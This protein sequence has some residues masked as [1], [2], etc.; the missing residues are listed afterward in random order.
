MYTY[1][2]VCIKRIAP[3]ALIFFYFVLCSRDVFA[4]QANT[5]HRESEV[6]ILE[7][8]IIW[9]SNVSVL[10]RTILMA[11]TSLKKGNC[12]PITSEELFSDLARY[13]HRSLTRCLS[14]PSSSIMRLAYYDIV[15]PLIFA[16]RMN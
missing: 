7:I 3:C 2:Y 5:L 1:M 10:V 11:T 8:L 13:S 4:P 6:A 9:K 16:R 14:V 15:Y 12:F